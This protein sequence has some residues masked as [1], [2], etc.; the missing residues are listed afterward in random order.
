L[1]LIQLRQYRF[2]ALPEFLEGILVDH[3]QCYDT[4]Q[5]RGIPSPKL[6]PKSDSAIV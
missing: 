5:T 3:P 6:Q 1:P 4:K 2:I